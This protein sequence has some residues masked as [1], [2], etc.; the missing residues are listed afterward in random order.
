[1][2]I[3]YEFALCHEMDPT[4]EFFALYPVQTKEVHGCVANS[5]MDCNSPCL[6][7]S[8]PHLEYTL[9]RLCQD[10]TKATS[11]TRRVRAALSLA[12]WRA[13]VTPMMWTICP[14]RA[15]CPAHARISVY[16]VLVALHASLFTC[17]L[18]IH[19]PWH[20]YCKA[21]STMSMLKGPDKPLPLGLANILIG[22]VL[23]E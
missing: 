7:P 11:P 8:L 17:V 20:Y 18:P 19:S 16:V 6:G 3:W 23:F 5:L 4:M 14:C 13:L 12:A 1:M 2:K 15:L 10:G 21:P 22:C 9:D